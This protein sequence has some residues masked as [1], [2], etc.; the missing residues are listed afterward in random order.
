MKIL[1]ITY[2]INGGAGKACKRLY[3]ALK[4]SNNEVKILK[5]KSNP[6]I[7]TVNNVILNTIKFTIRAVSNLE[8]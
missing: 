7:S 4:E 8:I 2:S 5:K 1:L 6:D 3:D